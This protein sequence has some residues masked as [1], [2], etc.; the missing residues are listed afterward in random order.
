MFV[1][2]EVFLRAHTR[3]QIVYQLTA[4]EPDS[5]CTMAS[6]NCVCVETLCSGQIT[7]RRCCR[8]SNTVVCDRHLN[9]VMRGIP[10]RLHQTLTGGTSGITIICDGTTFKCCNDYG[11]VVHCDDSYDAFMQWLQSQCFEIRWD[12]NEVVK[13]ELPEAELPEAE[14][15]KAEDTAKGVQRSCTD[16]RD[17]VPQQFVPQLSEAILITEMKA[18]ASQVQSSLRMMMNLMHQMHMGEVSSMG[19]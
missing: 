17:D 12:M 14:L 1:F 13:A 18:L 8:L 10:T 15:P 9:D 6:R 4:P 16:R 19:A 11:V 5:S 3:T 2:T 7:K